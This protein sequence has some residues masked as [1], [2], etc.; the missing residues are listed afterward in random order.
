MA[1]AAV[2]GF[3]PPVALAA[4]NDQGKRQPYLPSRRWVDGSL[5]DDLP[6]K[7]LSRLYGVNH[8]IVSQ[9]NPHIFPFV[10]DTKRKKDLLTTVKHAAGRTAREWI[11]ASASMLEKPLAWNSTVNRLTN[12]GLS[13]IN[14]DYFGDINILPDRRFFNPLKLLAHR[15]IEEV[16][17]LIEMG[18]KATWPKIEMIRLQTKVSKKLDQ[19][20]RHADRRKPNASDGVSRRAS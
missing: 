1:S 5:S 13:I 6:A 18:E 14:Q 3:Y 12:V 8:F 16:I 20:L 19:I 17:E 9:V 10:T 2:P 11:N 4:K 15:S 7:R